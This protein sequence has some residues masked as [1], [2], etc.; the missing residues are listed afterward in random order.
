MK[1]IF[2][3]LN[4]LKREETK[5]TPDEVVVSAAIHLMEKFLGDVQRIADALE[6]IADVQDGT[7]QRKWEN[8]YRERTG[9]S[10]VP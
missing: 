4:A 1:E 2:E 3:R 5:G 6:R 8:E 9:K 10:W 7:H